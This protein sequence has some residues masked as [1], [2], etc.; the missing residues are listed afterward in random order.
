MAKDL[1][2]LRGSVRI[3]V[4]DPDGIRFSD[5]DVDSAINQAYRRL[6]L[7]VLGANQNYFSVT[8]YHDITSGQSNIALPADHMRT[9]RLEYINGDIEIP[10]KKRDRGITANYT[11]GSNFNL[12]SNYFT[13]HFESSNLV[14]EPTPRVT[15]TNALKHTYIET[16]L[17]ADYM[18][19]DLDTVHV[20]IKD[21]WEDAIVLD[22]AT[23]LCSQLES[24]GADISNNLLDRLTL[25]T[26][27]VDK[28]LMLRSLSPNRNRRR[29]G[30][31]R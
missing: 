15:V 8:T 28:S 3:E 5:S 1:S 6:Y 4:R 19:A 11:G 25:A 31:F 30:Y 14:I 23:T 21:I 17:E 26:N 18:V 10:L 13:Y 20:D 2:T 12:A 22:A 7:R 29:K 24:I 16:L 27:A 9:V